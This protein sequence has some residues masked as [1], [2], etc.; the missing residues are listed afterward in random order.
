[1]TNEAADTT[2]HHHACPLC[3]AGC[4]LEI[5]VRDGAVALVRGDRA[6]V[7]SGGFLCPKA[8]ALKDLQHDPDRLRRPLV[9]RN[10]E[11]VEVDFDEAFAEVEAR[12][13]PAL[14]RHGRG[15]AGL[16]IGN[17]TVHRTGLVLYALALADA[18][19]SPN[20]FSAAS[21]DQMPKHLACGAMF[22]DWYTIPVPDIDRT[23]L[24]VI[25]GANP[26]VSNGSMWSVPDFRG[27]A[28]ALVARGGRIVTVDPRRT[29]TAELADVH[30]AIR[31]DTDVFLLAAIVRTLFRENR[32]RLGRLREH[33]AGLAELERAVEPFSIELAADRC[34]ITAVDIEHLA[35]DLSTVPRAAVYGRLGT[36]H[37]THGTLTSWLIDVVNTLTG[38]LDE[39]GGAMLACPPAFAA[40]TDGE[41]GRGQGVATGSYR[42]RVSAAPEVMGQ[43]PMSCLAEEID[44][45]GEGQI[46]ALITIAS[47]PARS[48]PHS[49]RVERALSDL[50]FLLCLD[51]YVNETTRH[52][53]VII[54]GPSP[55]E[56]THYDLFFSQFAYRNTARFSAPVLDRR[57]GVPEDWETMVRLVAILRG[58]GSNADIDRVDDDLLRTTLSR[59]VPDFADAILAALAPR[60]GAERLVDLGI[61]S[62]P[63]GDQF[64]LVPDGLTLDRLVEHPS[65]IDFGPLE[66]R[67]P[68]ALRTPSGKVELAPTEFVDALAIA[69][70]ELHA[71]T[72]ACV[73]IGRRDLRSNNSWM[74]NLPVLA[75]GRDRCTLLVHPDDI[76]RFGLRDD[77][78]AKVT[79]PRTDES[80]TAVVE[81]DN[82]MRPGVVSLPHGWG[83]DAPDSRLG[84]AK[85]RPGVNANALTDPDRRD[86]LSGNAAFG[87]TEVRIEAVEPV[88][89]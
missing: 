26:M 54:P 77:S 51:V 58:E 57:A 31:P 86:P 35:R 73:L 56:E 65:G 85:L 60:R 46:R 8:T 62:G 64:G 59:R 41:P 67:L 36:C 32:T 45:P 30:L 49:R 14:E 17:P 3:E 53:D 80:V 11:F 66:P 12:L 9:R 55:L 43:F 84:V 71:A 5:T 21:L 39:P 74:H 15:A 24:L 82:S 4:G 47:N 78:S 70:D 22:G 63:Y 28:R 50:D 76:A 68:E 61:R 25:I 52:A 34:G 69:A 18:L 83:H 1:M 10:G 29:E 38:N 7:H 72:P 19:G 79:N 6:D 75:K 88:M 2:T 42:S 16:V 40:N 33:L 89:P 37:Q 87:N 23:D 48:A 20:V 13:L 27:R 44:T 81:V